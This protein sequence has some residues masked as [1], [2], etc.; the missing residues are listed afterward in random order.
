[1]LHLR[2]GYPTPRPRTVTGLRPVRNG[3]AQQEVSGG[4]ASEA[5]SAVPHRSRYHLNHPTIP[6]PHPHP[7]PGP[8]KNCLPRNWSLVPKRL[9][10]TDLRYTPRSWSYNEHTHTHRH[11]QFGGNRKLIQVQSNYITCMAFPKKEKHKHKKLIKTHH[12]LRA[13][14]FHIYEKDVRYCKIHQ[15]SL[16]VSRCCCCLWHSLLDQ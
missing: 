4:L 8:W 3:A 14:M 6:H 15:D 5:S 16:S 2:Q 1:M 12:T 13:D 9:G 11:T 7:A 10:T